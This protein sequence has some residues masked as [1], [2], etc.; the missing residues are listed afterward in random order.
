M[1][2]NLTFQSRNVLSKKLMK[3]QAKKAGEAEQ[4]APGIDNINLFQIITILSFL[5]LM[6]INLMVEGWKMSPAGLAALVR[7][8][9]Y[10]FAFA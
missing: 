9:S 8:P 6:P 1:G 2:S 7:A 4:E 10:C 3:G 5:L